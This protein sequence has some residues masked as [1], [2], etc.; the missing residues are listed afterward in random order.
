[1]TRIQEYVFFKR[2]SNLSF[3]EKIIL[4]GSRARGD[5]AERSDIDIAIVCPQATENDWFKVLHIIDQADTLLKIDCV[6][7]DA[8]SVDSSL[9]KSIESQGIVV[10][11]RKS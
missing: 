5:N 4:Y 9:K 1:M 11:Q 2:L 6:R 3:V 10:Y 8:L 7:F